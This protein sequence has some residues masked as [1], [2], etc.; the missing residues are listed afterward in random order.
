MATTF[1]I[2]SKT[3]GKAV[4][5]NKFDEL[6]CSETGVAC[7]SRRYAIWFSLTECILNN[8]GA[9]ADRMADCLLKE[10]FVSEKRQISFHEAARCLLICCSTWTYRG[11][12]YKDVKETFESISPFVKFLLD[13]Q[14]EY[15]FIYSF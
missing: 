1:Q 3:T 8:H 11:E 13:H 4:N 6:Y 12:K 9:F 15:Y 14:N 10:S 5:L 2:I 7:D